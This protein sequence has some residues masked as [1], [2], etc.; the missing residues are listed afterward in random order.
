MKT[1]ISIILLVLAV[2]VNSTRLNLRGRRAMMEK[3]KQKE[4]RVSPKVALYLQ[5]KLIRKG[6]DDRLAKLLLQKKLRKFL[7]S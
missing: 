7:Q 1:F 2:L 6:N 3:M 4:K 5:K